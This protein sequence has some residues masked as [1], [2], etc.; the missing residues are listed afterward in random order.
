M[1]SRYYH[2][3]AHLATAKELG[4]EPTQFR[5]QHPDIKEPIR[6]F[7]RR[8]ASVAHPDSKE[9]ISI[10]E[11]RT[12]RLRRPSSASGYEY[13]PYTHVF[14]ENDSQK[15]V[16]ESSC[17]PLVQGLFEGC[18]GMY[19]TY[20]K[21]ESGKT[22]SAYGGNLSFN[23]KK[24]Q[25]G[26][27]PRVIDSIFGNMRYFQADRL[28]FKYNALNGFDF[29]LEDFYKQADKKCPWTTINP[30]CGSSLDSV[31]AQ[32]AFE[33]SHENN[34]TS[35]VNWSHCNNHDNEWLNSSY[36]EEPD[37]DSVLKLIVDLDFA[38]SVFVSCCEVY[39][40]RVYDLLEGP[41]LLDT[42]VALRPERS[43]V[44]KR[45]D[46]DTQDVKFVKRLATAEVK[47]AMEAR[48]IIQ[49]AQN[50]RHQ[51]SHLVF[52]VTICRAPLDPRGEHVLAEPGLV[53]V[54]TLSIVDLSWGNVPKLTPLLRTPAKT[55]EEKIDRRDAFM[56]GGSLK[57]LH[58]CLETLRQNQMSLATT[59]TFVPY[60]D[61]KLTQ[62]LKRFF[63]YPA[64]VVVLLCFE[65]NITSGKDF[66][67]VKQILEFGSLAGDVCTPR[68]VLFK[69]VEGCTRGRGIRARLHAMKK[70][71]AQRRCAPAIPK[72]HRS[73]SEIT[74]NF[75]S[76]QDS[77]NT[78][79]SDST[80]KGKKEAARSTVEQRDM[81]TSPREEPPDYEHLDE[82]ENS[83]VEDRENTIK[84]LSG[85]EE[86]YPPIGFKPEFLPEKVDKAQFQELN[87]EM[88]HVSLN[89]LRN[90]SRT[91]SSTSVASSLYPPP[92]MGESNIPLYPPM[93]YM[94]SSAHVQK[95]PG[96]PPL[97]P[98]PALYPATIVPAPLA[99]PGG[100]GENPLEKE[101]LQQNAPSNPLNPTSKVGNNIAP[102]QERYYAQFR[103]QSAPGAPYR[104]APQSKSQMVFAKDD[105]PPNVKHVA[106]SFEKATQPPP[107]PPL[108]P[109]EERPKR[110]S[111]RSAC[112]KVMDKIRASK[113]GSSGGFADVVKQATKNE[114]AME[115]TSRRPP[116]PQKSNS[117]SIPPV[118][119]VSTNSLNKGK[120]KVT[121][122]MN[123]TTRS[124]PSSSSALSEKIEPEDD[125][126]NKLRAAYRVNRV[127][128]FES[129]LA[130]PKTNDESSYESG[131]SEGSIDSRDYVSTSSSEYDSKDLYGERDEYG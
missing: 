5:P 104:K 15:E 89:S 82:K 44:K 57:A 93:N 8:R 76:N 71:R 131:D 103:P 125:I 126:M 56:R 10:E 11:G 18:N 81:A 75:M 31:G 45:V 24:S 79:D 43:H 59:Q 58:N 69:P 37:F 111:L 12:L 102:E 99:G 1:G 100:S 78:S 87:R 28:V 47:S 61:S 35:Y 77:G 13:Y 66:Q 21:E 62:I 64:R 7:A 20:G 105:E 101:I 114:N 16:F 60:S 46:V 2:C 119:A 32:K 95:I 52:S 50:H 83:E 49:R 53:N 22:Y 26:I 68:P 123:A 54:S 107:P 108:I 25:T 117:P 30:G 129:G 72:I 33:D 14:Y 4:F 63:E 127:R 112:N 9:V 19:M 98:S 80:K 110:L 55:K 109:K 118:K 128:S 85:D 115:G 97:T 90:V 70:A 96:A 29:E 91:E 116:V 88:S 74:S 39:N 124:L 94:D 86:F 42:R 106:S 51:G 34:A 121:F 40:E 6:V 65:P 113:N 3:P 67:R 122:D 41:L 120:E 84:T 27:V 92:N 73:I 130:P 23:T 38:Y 17:L 36:K 48:T